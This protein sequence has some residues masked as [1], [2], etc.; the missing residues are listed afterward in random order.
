VKE[1]VLGQNRGI[2]QKH[3]LCSLLAEVH[4]A[5]FATANRQCP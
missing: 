4:L 2:I 1:E 3:T 5:G